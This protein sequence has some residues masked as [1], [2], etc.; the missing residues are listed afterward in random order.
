MSKKTKLFSYLLSG[1]LIASSF[2][3]CA[4]SQSSKSSSSS[5]SS[6]G[7]SEYTLEA[8]YAQAQDLGF[9]GS[10]EEFK[11]YVKGDEGVGVEEVYVEGG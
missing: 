5:S 7:A 4:G 1:L 3:G 9:E 11:E 10:L 2:A 6:G 8:I